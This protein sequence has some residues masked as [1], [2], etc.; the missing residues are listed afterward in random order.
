[1]PK[2]PEDL[3]LIMQNLI[4]DEDLDHLSLKDLRNI[5]LNIQPVINS[6][7]EESE[8]D[9]ALEEEEIRRYVL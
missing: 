2:Q 5:L 4:N 6:E 9:E 7:D 3:A 8:E 1:M